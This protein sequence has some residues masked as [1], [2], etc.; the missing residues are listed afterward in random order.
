MPDKLNSKDLENAILWLRKQFPTQGLKYYNLKK[1]KEQLE[2][3]QE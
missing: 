2:K 3:M 1:S